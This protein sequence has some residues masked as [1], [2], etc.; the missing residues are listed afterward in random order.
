[1]PTCIRP[2]RAWGIS[3]PYFC[4]F[5]PFLSPVPYQVFFFAAAALNPATSLTPEGQEYSFLL[6]RHILRTWPFLRSD[7]R[8]SFLPWQHKDFP[9]FRRLSACS[10]LTSTSVIFP[11]AFLQWHWQRRRPPRILFRPGSILIF[12]WLD[13]VLTGCP[14]P[15]TF[16][17]VLSNVMTK[18]TSERIVLREASSFLSARPDEYQRWHPDD[19]P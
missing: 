8:F 4:H 19:P 5:I 11:D 15:Q 2:G 12:R 14:L 13:I 6:R 16:L 10:I 17:P 7:S 18:S 9:A 1:M 3:C